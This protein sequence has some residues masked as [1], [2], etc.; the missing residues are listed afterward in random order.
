M[1]V[2]SKYLVGLF[3]C[4]SALNAQKTYAQTGS[5]SGIVKDSASGEEMIGAIV[6]IDGTNQGASV[7]IN[8]AFE[9]KNVKPGKYTVKTQLAGY[10]SNTITDVVV[11]TNE[12]TKLNIQLSEDSYQL[13]AV[14]ITA[15]RRTNTVNSVIEEEKNSDQVVDGISGDQ[16][17]TS[18]DRDAGQVIQRIPGVTIINNRFVL[19]R[20]L[21]ERYNNVMIN[22]AISPSTEADRRSFSFDLIPTNML[23]RMLIYKSG[24]AD[25]PGDFAGG[26]IKIYTRSV[27]ANN[28][29]NL[30]I[31]TGYRNETTFNPYLRTNKSA[32]D[33]LGF[34]SK[35]RKLPDDFP[36]RLNE[37]SNVQLAEESKRLA[38]N[39]K[40]EERTAIPD[41]RIN[42]DLS[43][44]FNIGNKE[45]GMVAAV[46]Y[47]NTYQYFKAYRNRYLEYETD[48]GESPLQD[49]FNDDVYT[50]NVRLGLL[51]NWFLKFNNDHSIE[52]KNMFNQLGES[53]TIIRNGV[54]LIQRSG[55]SLRNYSFRYS[56]RS[57]YTGQ[58]SGTHEFNEDKTKFHWVTGLSYINREIPDLRRMRTFTRIGSNE[59]YKVI[60]PPTATTFDA[61]RFYSELNERTIMNAGDFEHKFYKAE[62]DTGIVFKA[63]YYIEQKSRS[64]QARWTSYKSSN[65][66]AADVLSNLPIDE[67]FAPENMNSSNG[68]FLTEGTNPS[69]KYDAQNLLTAGYANLLIPYRKFKVI[70]GVRTEYNILSLQSATQLSKIEVN[71]PVLSVLPFVNVAYNITPKMLVRTAYGKTVNRQEF[72]EMAPFLFYDFDF[73]FDVIGNPDLQIANIHNV[74]LRWELYPSVGESFSVGAFYKK[75]IDPIESYIRQGADNPI[76]T[77]GNAAS[78]Y[79]YG[80]EVDL[81]KSLYNLSSNNFIKRL[82]VVFNG[83]IIKSEVDLGDNVT[84]QDTIRPLQGQ[85]PYIVNGGIYYINED[86]GF[87]CNIMYNIFGKRIF[88]VGDRIN[89]TIY[90]MPRHSLDITINKRISEKVEIRFGVQDVLNYPVQL[91]QDSDLNTKIT[92]VDE[93]VLTFRRGTYFTAGL[94]FRF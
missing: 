85:S 91:I 18:Q 59:P 23:D 1:R 51:N 5:I 21:G 49:Q 83:A 39:F 94:N 61:A 79:N 77:F 67:I 48:L 37:L 46:N 22:D 72:R 3:L 74:D 45:A 20:G 8:G 11:K 28:S 17:R 60:I 69:D 15:Q 63:G 90:E 12:V 55:D 89:P 92:S 2:L 9:I 62:K 4:F 6:F 80:L 84:A 58:L 53:E 57:L 54:N 87:S 31:T 47:S 40:I 13:A 64:F 93:S 16:A 50:N 19:I 75:F 41:I 33:F 10:R 82:S 7:D 24:S 25:L 38:N 88:I 34:G 81:R 73:N 14:E 43:R 70:S 68:L 32:T 52:F 44:K 29:F 78:A 27:P 30:T 26:V 71:N 42:S 66:L 56:S 35:N 76:F 86:K 36:S 65:N